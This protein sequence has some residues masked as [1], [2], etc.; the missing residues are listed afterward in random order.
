MTAINTNTGTVYN[1]DGIQVN[2]PITFDFI[3][4]ETGVIKVYLIDNLGVRV[5]QVIAADY[6]LD[7][8]NNPTQGTQQFKR[9]SGVV[10]ATIDKPSIKAFLEI[11]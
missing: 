6:T 10:N 3:S 4:G 11:A 7:D 8:I 2:F 1:G 9:A 5:L